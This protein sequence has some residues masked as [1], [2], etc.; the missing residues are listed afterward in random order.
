[1]RHHV[2]NISLDILLVYSCTS[3]ICSININHNRILAN[4]VFS[5]EYLSARTESTTITNRFRL[6][7]DELGFDSE[8]EHMTLQAPPPALMVRLRRTF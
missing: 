3:C 4:L 2:R 1:M 5:L 8:S 6:G 7:T